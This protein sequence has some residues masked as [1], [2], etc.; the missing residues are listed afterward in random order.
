M[1][2]GDIVRCKADVWFNAYGDE[3]RMVTR[4]DPPRLV[5]ESRRF[6]GANFLR[7]D[8]VPNL[9][10]WDDGFVRVDRKGLN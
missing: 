8:D 5:V 1:R 3:N 10:F 9:W 2:A 6:G 7:F 4:H